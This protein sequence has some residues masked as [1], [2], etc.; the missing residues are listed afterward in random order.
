MPISR[1][2]TTACTV[3]TPS[4]DAVDSDTDADGV[5]S[6]SV[7]SVETHCAIQPYRPGDEDTLGRTDAERARR[8]WFPAATNITYGSTVDI[9]SDRYEVWGDPGTWSVGST[10]DHIACIL[11]RREHRSSGTGG[12][13]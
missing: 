1:F 3:R 5:P 13:S 11:V 7:D 12:S 8:A 9:G 4:P 2:F 10:N 6:V